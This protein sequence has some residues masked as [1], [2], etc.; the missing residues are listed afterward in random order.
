MTQS[1]G[2]RTLLVLIAVVVGFAALKATQPITLPL[3]FA[4]VLLLF[5]RPLQ[6]WLDKRL[7]HWLSPLLIVLL[8]LALVGFGALAVGYGVSTIAPEVPRYVEQLQPQLESLQAR[9]REIGIGTGGGEAGGG[10]PEGLSQALSG[11]ASG[12]GSFMSALGV[13]IL[14]LTVL[15]FLLFEVKDYRKKFERG[16]LP[17]PNNSKVIHAFERMSSKFARYFIVQVF[18]SL[19]TGILVGL[20]CWLVGVEFPFVWGLLTAILNFIPTVGSIVGVVPPTLFALAFG[21]LGTGVLVLAG[22]TVIEFAM[23]NLVDPALQG[24]ALKLSKVV[25]LLSVVFWGWLWGI[26]GAFLAVPLTTAVILLCD[27]FEATRPISRLLGE[28]PE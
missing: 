4:I 21:G 28:V 27:E 18:V 13:A 7:P 25:M 20:Y 17:G 12:L 10:G 15:V 1:S 14:A 8:I 9:L 5:F 22:L 6:L 19:L 24:N 11:I 23:G 3:V 16:V 26:G 2:V